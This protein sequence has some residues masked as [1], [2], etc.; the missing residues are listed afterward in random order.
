MEW[1]FRAEK[2]GLYASCV[3]RIVEFPAV[4]AK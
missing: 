3:V 1:Y 2:I 4:E